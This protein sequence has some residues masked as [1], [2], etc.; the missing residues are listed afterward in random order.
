MYAAVVLCMMEEH[1]LLLAS[2]NLKRKHVKDIL[3]RYDLLSGPERKGEEG[4]IDHSTTYIGISIEHYEPNF[5]RMPVKEGINPNTYVPI[6]QI[7]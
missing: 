4:A 3:Q 6:C 7:L 2:G 5:S 1:N